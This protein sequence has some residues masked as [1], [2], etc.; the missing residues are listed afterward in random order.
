MNLSGFMICSFLVEATNTSVDAAI[1][2]FGLARAP[3][4]YHYT[5]L[6]ELFRRYDDATLAE[7]R[8]LA[9]E[10]AV[11]TPDWDIPS[12]SRRSRTAND[13]D[14]RGGSHSLAALHPI[15][16]LLRPVKSIHVERLQ[17]LCATYVFNIV[18]H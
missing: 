9:E 2:N 8:E 6:T 5:W 17:K 3:G 15:M 16:E 1:T 7:A 12:M 10:C 14:G 4:I 18:N 11:S 13:N